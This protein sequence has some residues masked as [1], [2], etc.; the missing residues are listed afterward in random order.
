MPD[1]YIHNHK[2]IVDNVGEKELKITVF[3]LPPLIVQVYFDVIEVK[4]LQVFVLLD[5]IAK[6]EF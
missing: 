2:N 6:E 3:E 1:C 5:N 4:N